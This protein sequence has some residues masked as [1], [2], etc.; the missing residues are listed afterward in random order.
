MAVVEVFN[1][2]GHDSEALLIT[3][4]ARKGVLVPGPVDGCHI[5]W[6]T[7]PFG[8]AIAKVDERDSDA[9]EGKPSRRVCGNDD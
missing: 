2:F 9:M 4:A 1:L 5:N 8:Q 3:A 6:T 7:K